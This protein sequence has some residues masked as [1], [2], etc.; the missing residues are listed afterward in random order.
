M[1]PA[2]PF[3]ALARCDSRLWPYGASRL[4]SSFSRLRTRGNHAFGEAK[5][6]LTAKKEILYGIHPVS[7]AITCKSRR[8]SKGYIALGDVNDASSIVQSTLV[9]LL[10]SELRVPL[11]RCEK[12]YLDS[13]TRNASHQG[14]MLEVSGIEEEVQEL[15]YGMEVQGI[16]PLVK[17][18]HPLLLVLDELTDPHNVGAVLRNAA[19]LG[20]DA[21]VVTKGNTSPLNATVSKTS[22]GALELWFAANRLFFARNL[23]VVLQSLVAAEWRVIG[24]V[25]PPSEA[26]TQDDEVAQHDSVQ[27]SDKYFGIETMSALE[28]VRD[29]PTVLVLGNEGRGIRASVLKSCSLL[30]YMPMNENLLNSVV[31]NPSIDHD[32]RRHPSPIGTNSMQSYSGLPLLKSLNVAAAA[33]VMLQ[34]LRVPFRKD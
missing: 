18:S 8:I 7:T 4:F 10:E 20:A 5:P 25:E 11:V 28:L 12:S 21:V 2:A 33:A 23:P 26:N 17:G 3:R 24:C 6:K 30:A 27:K 22:A 16:T 31:S 9:P 32:T 34:Q 14:I 29:Q 19:L 13:R 15:P 1:P